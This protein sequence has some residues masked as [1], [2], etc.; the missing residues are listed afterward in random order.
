MK[1]THTHSNGLII[2]PTSIAETGTLYWVAK[3]YEGKRMVMVFDTHS[4][5]T[6]QEMSDVENQSPAL[7]INEVD[8]DFEGLKAKYQKMVDDSR[9]WREV[10]ATLS[11]EVDRLK[12]E[13]LQRQ[14][15]Y[16]RK[17]RK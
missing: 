4:V 9:H 16:K 12:A 2:V 17:S 1:I 15:T 14:V 5:P 7:F 3:R 10:S 13:L 11:N 6:S 8:D